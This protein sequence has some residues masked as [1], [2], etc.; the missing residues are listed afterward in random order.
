[1]VQAGYTI[2]DDY[3]EGFFDQF[4][5]FTGN[6]PTN[7]YVNYVDQSTAN[8][9]GYVKKNTDGSVYIGVDFNNV[10]SG[11]GRD[12]VRL[13]TKNTYTHMLAVVDVAHMPGGTCGTWPAF[14]SFG[15]GG[16]GWPSQGEIDIIEGANDQTQNYMTLH[17]SP[18]CSISSSTQSLVQSA[19]QN[20]D[21]QVDGN[22]GCSFHDADSKSYGAGFNSNGGGVY[23]TEWTSLGVSMWFFPRGSEPSDVLGSDPNPSNW[24]E[25][26]ATW[27][28][29]GCD[30]DSH[31][32]DHNLIFDTTFCGDWGSNTFDSCSA[33]NN[34]QTCQQFVQNNPSAFKNAYWQINNLKVYQDGGSASPSEPSSSA[35]PSTQAVSSPA[36]VST[37]PAPQV[38]TT[39]VVT[40]SSPAASASNGGGFL[41]TPVASDP[42][43]SPST[44][45]AAPETPS[46]STPAVAPTP[47]SG[48]Q[49]LGEDPDGGVFQSAPPSPAQSPDILTEADNGQVRDDVDKRYASM[50][51]ARRRQGHLRKHALREGVKH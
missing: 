45:A 18:G 29:D 7:G 41:Q 36:A 32:L 49:F 33:A 48:G 22:V 2:A 39:F 38:T 28:G 11:R 14:W 27:G 34:G 12:S 44:P 46:P 43:P 25:P 37:T 19:S 26:S 47:S 40:T 21:T 6:D 8:S 23:A 15:N 51:M 20:C 16:S 9:A 30:W 35:Q 31:F 50:R 17:S 4:D 5:F 24:G 10:A 1:M 3:M 13:S 42:V